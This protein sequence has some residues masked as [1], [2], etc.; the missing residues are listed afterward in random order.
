MTEFAAALLPSVTWEIFNTADVDR[1]G[2]VPKAKLPDMLSSLSM[3]KGHRKHPKF[4]SVLKEALNDFG[5]DTPESV[6]D[7]DD[8]FRIAARMGNAASEPLL[9]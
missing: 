2:H 1:Q 7:Y 5:K 4:D 6:I 3:K 8:F 9:T